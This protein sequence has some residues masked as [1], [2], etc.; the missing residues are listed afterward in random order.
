MTTI[1]NGL[2]AAAFS[3]LVAC[4]TPVLN[5]LDDLRPSHQE[6]L[7]RI[8]ANYGVYR[9]AKVRLSENGYS[10]TCDRYNHFD[11]NVHDARLSWNDRVFHDHMLD[12]ILD[13][14]TYTGEE[15]TPANE[16]RPKILEQLQNEYT[17]R[18]E[19][20]RQPEIHEWWLENW[21]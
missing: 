2:I 19:D 9:V 1:K 4:S 17:G 12:G 7:L 18:L 11:F 16:I 21:R 13:G 5:N 10:I 6:F 15:Y 3:G 20:I 8:S 14:V